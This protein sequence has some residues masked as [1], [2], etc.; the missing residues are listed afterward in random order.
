MND[1]NKEYLVLSERI[2]EQLEKQNMTQRELADKT[3]MTEVSIS[4]YVSGQRMPNGVHI[5]KIAKALNVS[6][7]YL[8][9]LTD[10]ELGSLVSQDNVLELIGRLA[11]DVLVLPTVKM[12][13]KQDE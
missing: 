13:G 7:D 3:G 10:N 2:K 4:R 1:K 9:G 6:C 8:T 11:H 5:V 12:K